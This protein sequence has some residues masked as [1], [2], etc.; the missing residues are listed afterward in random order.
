MPD[1]V[2]HR[3]QQVWLICDINEYIWHTPNSFILKEIHIVIYLLQGLKTR[4]RWNKQ[5]VSNTGL[6]AQ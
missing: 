2:G 1:D 6:L 4:T 3:Y 5:D